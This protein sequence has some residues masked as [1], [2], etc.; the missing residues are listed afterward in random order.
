MDRKHTRRVAGDKVNIFFA[1][2][3]VYSNSLDRH[4]N[5]DAPDLRRERRA[6]RD[7]KEMPK[8]HVRQHALRLVPA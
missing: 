3:Q 1:S 6:R 4:A 5:N 2:R 8:L 7:V